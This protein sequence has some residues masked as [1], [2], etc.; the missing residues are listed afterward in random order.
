MSPRYHPRFSTRTRWNT[1]IGRSPIVSNGGKP[2]RPSIIHTELLNYIKPRN[3]A[4]GRAIEDHWLE[5][6]ELEHQDLSVCKKCKRSADL[7]EG[8]MMNVPL[9][10]LYAT[11]V[12][13]ETLYA[14]S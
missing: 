12:P 3:T 11:S 9:E 5:Y 13:L 6:D 8:L 1:A 4:C 14:T 10:T 2:S 7:Q